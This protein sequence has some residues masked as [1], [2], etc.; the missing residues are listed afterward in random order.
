MARTEGATVIASTAF[1]LTMQNYDLRNSVGYLL[2]LNSKIFTQLAEDSFAADS[3]LSFVQ[4]ISIMLVRDGIASTPGDLTRLLGYNSGAIT[5]LVDKLEEDGLVTRRRRD[6]D[7]RSI[8]LAIT[9]VGV[10]AISRLLPLLLTLWNGVLSG[11]TAEEY[12]ELV[13]LQR[14]LLAAVATAAG[15]PMAV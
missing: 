7:R 2:K 6:C 1:P 8:A 13:R 11:F 4:F 14:K 9:P 15:D 12:V 3:N 5:R 10:A